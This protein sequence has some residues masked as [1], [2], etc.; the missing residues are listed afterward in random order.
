MDD[1]ESLCFYYI[2]WYQTDTIDT[3]YDCL[4][5]IAL[6]VLTAFAINF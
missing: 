2:F 1:S 4:D 6:F 5:H 3:F